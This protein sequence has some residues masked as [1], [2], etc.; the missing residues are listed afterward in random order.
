M[1]AKG[2][3][4]GQ[5]LQQVAQASS[6]VHLGDK[7]RNVGIHGDFMVINWDFHG[8]SWDCIGLYIRILWNGIS[9]VFFGIP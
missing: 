1:N 9:M 3:A 7:H 5:G 2:N 4:P 6:S 8:T